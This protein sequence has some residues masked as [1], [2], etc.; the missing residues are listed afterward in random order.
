MCS[1]IE[2][3]CSTEKPINSNYVNELVFMIK[4]LYRLYKKLYHF[5]SQKYREL[6]CDI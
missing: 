3:L 2:Q 6:N 4:L 1:E 5:V